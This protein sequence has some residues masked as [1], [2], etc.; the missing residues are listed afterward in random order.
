MRNSPGPNLSIDT[1]HLNESTQ[2]ATMTGQEYMYE[3]SAHSRNSSSN[4]ENYSPVT[5]T[6]SLREH[7]RVASSTSS[8]ASTP[9]SYEYLD[10]PPDPPKTMLHDLV[11]DPYEREDDFDPCADAGHTRNSWG[12]Q[13]PHQCPPI[14]S[15]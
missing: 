4:S 14:H 15:S 13:I 10:S 2:K 12:M 1:I 7:S 3:A 5:P 9:P 11:E 8:L 6:F